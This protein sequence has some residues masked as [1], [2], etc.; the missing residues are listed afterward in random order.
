MFQ[1]VFQQP[2]AAFLFFNINLNIK[3][4]ISIVVKQIVY[5]RNDIWNE[6]GG[7]R[8]FMGQIRPYALYFLHLFIARSENADHGLLRWANLSLASRPRNHGG[9]LAIFR[10]FKKKKEKKSFSILH[11][12]LI[13]ENLSLFFNFFTLF[14]IKCVLFVHVSQSERG[15]CFC[16]G[17]IKTKFSIF[18]FSTLCSMGNYILYKKNRSICLIFRNISETAKT[19]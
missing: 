7:A 13:F 3:V 16:Q 6:F 19:I 2:F 17:R 10:L 12:F 8:S 14:L 18:F 4:I 15:R 11:D 5:F 9:T 1:L